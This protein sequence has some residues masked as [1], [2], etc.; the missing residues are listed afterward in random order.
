MK[1]CKTILKNLGIRRNLGH[2]RNHFTR[3]YTR[4]S[5]VQG[6]KEIKW[7]TG[8]TT[9]NNVWRKKIFYNCLTLHFYQRRNLFNHDEAAQLLTEYLSD[10]QLCSHTR[11]GICLVQ[12]TPLLGWTNQS[13]Q[14]AIKQ[15]HGFLPDKLPLSPAN[16]LEVRAAQSCLPQ[17][18]QLLLRLCSVFSLIIQ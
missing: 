3:H 18:F 17:G 15:L 4:I 6:K 8:N 7:K 13:Q 14:S 1:L 12:H 11:E 9:Q 2:L 10:L 5:S 16:T